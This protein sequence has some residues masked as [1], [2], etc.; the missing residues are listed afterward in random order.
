MRVAIIGAGIGGLYAAY[1]LSSSSVDDVEK[2]DVFEKAA[3]VGGRVRTVG[4]GGMIVEAGAG[5]VRSTDRLLLKLA[6]ELGIELVDTG[7]VR[8]AYYRDG[9]LVSRRSSLSLAAVLNDV[10]DVRKDATVTLDAWLRDR[11]DGTV[12][13]DVVHEAG[14]DSCFEKANA[15]DGYDQLS[16]IANVPGFFR[17]VGGMSTFVQRLLV[18]LS[19]DKRVSIHLNAPVREADVRRFCETYDHVLAT[20]TAPDLTELDVSSASVGS[21]LTRVYARFDPA[22]VAKDDFISKI[23]HATCNSPV[24]QFIPID[25]KKGI[26]MASYCTDRWASNWLQPMTKRT[27]K[28]VLAKR[29]SAAFG[30]EIPEPVEVDVHAWRVGAHSWGVSRESGRGSVDKTFAHPYGKRFRVCG[31]VASVKNHGWIEGALDSVEREVR[32]IVGR[33]L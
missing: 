20:V 29:L 33:H 17:A 13:D 8:N 2:I 22:D 24:R 30:R 16:R 15:L 1:K 6:E 19:T 27:L 26:V 11:Y 32:S 7:G 25:A 10:A 12:V 3:H 5:R 31:E 4:F 21:P 23:G 28:R 14:Y 18:R 9:K